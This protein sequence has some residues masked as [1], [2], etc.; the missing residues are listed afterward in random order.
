MYF[1]TIIQSDFKRLALILK[2][3]F[4]TLYQLL[5]FLVGSMEVVMTFLV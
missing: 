2:Q 3:C 5:I 4:S 1:Q